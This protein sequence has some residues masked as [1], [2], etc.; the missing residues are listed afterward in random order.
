MILSLLSAPTPSMCFDRTMELNDLMD[1]VCD[2]WEMDFELDMATS[3]LECDE[4]FLEPYVL[5]LKAEIGPEA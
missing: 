4:K 3:C 2:F 5:F 1:A